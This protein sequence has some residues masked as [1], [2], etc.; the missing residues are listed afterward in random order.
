MRKAADLEKQVCATC[1][2]WGDSTANE[3]NWY[4]AREKVEG[5][6]R[7]QKSGVWSQN[8]EHLVRTF[9]SVFR[10]V[11]SLLTAWVLLPEQK[12][13]LAG[14]QCKPWAEPTEMARK[15]RL[16]PGG[17]ERFDPS[18]VGKLGWH[19]IR[20]RRA[21]N[22]APLPTAT[23]LQPLRGSDEKAG[24]IDLGPVRAARRGVAGVDCAG[25]H[26]RPEGNL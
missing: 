4:P 3:G 26:G 23:H 15:K 11:R 13:L 14:Q 21:Q 10:A 8:E 7:S 22:P 18:R 16:V 19:A 5:K 24:Y 2:L 1:L 20:G 25:L 9:C 12:P 6:S 17:D